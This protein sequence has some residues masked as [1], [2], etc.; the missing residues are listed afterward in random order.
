MGEIIR[1][2]TERGGWSL[3]GRLTDGTFKYCPTFFMQLYT[4]HGTVNGHSNALAFVSIH[5]IG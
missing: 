1:T 4:I 2:T 3:D 5:L